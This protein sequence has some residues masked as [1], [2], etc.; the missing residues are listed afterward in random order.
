[1]D[2]ADPELLSRLTGILA[3]LRRPEWI[4]IH[5]LRAWTAGGRLHTDFHL[6]VPRYWDLDR[7]HE[8]QQVLAAALLAELGQVGEVLVHV[9]PCSETV[10]RFCAV[11]DCPV[12]TEET[13]VQVP[14]TVETLV[15]VRPGDAED[16]CRSVWS[17]AAPA[18]D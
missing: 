17:G 14:W 11:P 7:V 9:D 18:R 4:D 5:L 15:R 10:C 13:R 8:T 2:R 3:G 6:T 1:M 12:R 16:S